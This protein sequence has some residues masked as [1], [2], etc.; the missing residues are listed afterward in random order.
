MEENKVGPIA[1]M[2]LG[3]LVLIAGAFFGGK[4]DEK[5][6]PAS[7]LKGTLLLVV[8]EKSSPPIDETIE[9]RRASEFVKETGFDSFLVVD[10]DDPNFAALINAVANREIKPPF[11]AA[12]RMEHQKLVELIKAVEWKDSL[13]DI[14]K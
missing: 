6:E 7:G 12:G 14:L 8:H 9:L 10:Q 2:I 13:E 3:G 11:L 1:A 4:P 5:P